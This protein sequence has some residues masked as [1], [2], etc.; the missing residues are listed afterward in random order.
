MFVSWGTAV[1]DAEQRKPAH[2]TLPCLSVVRQLNVITILTT[3]TDN[4]EK[5]LEFLNNQRGPIHWR[6]WTAYIF[7]SW[8]PA[9]KVRKT[10][11][12]YSTADNP[13]RKVRKTGGQYSTADNPTR[14]V[15]KTGGLYYTAD[16]PTRKVWN[17]GGLYSTADNPTRKVWNIGG[18]YSAVD[19]PTRKVWNIGGLY[20]TAKN[21]TRKVWNIGGLYFTVDNP[22]SKLFWKTGGLYPIADN[23]PA[24]SEILV[25]CMLQLTASQQGLKDWWTVFYSWQPSQQGLGDWWI[26][27]YCWQPSQQG[28]EDWWTVSYS[29]QPNQK[30]Q[31][32]ISAHVD[33]LLAQVQGIIPA[34]LSD[35][36]REWYKHQHVWVTEAVFLHHVYAPLQQSTDNGETKEKWKN[37][38]KEP[39]KEKHVPMW[40]I[41]ITHIMIGKVTSANNRATCPCMYANDLE[42][43]LWFP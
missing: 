7:Y 16:N 23:Q 14:K 20:S 35:R 41:M 18:L 15:R 33:L 10:G 5:R 3:H 30:G 42:I 37:K 11:G 27:F 29:W 12:Q 32:D 31:R 26:V 38:N 17:I 39:Y 22:T 6:D 34:T 24:R 4:W 40:S 36:A 1:H 28:R 19:N 8:Q 13:T 25:D 2:Q 21:P 9:S 43:N